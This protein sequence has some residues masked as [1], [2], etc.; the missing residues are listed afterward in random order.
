MLLAAEST[1]PSGGG[2]VRPCTFLPLSASTLK[3]KIKKERGGAASLRVS[4]QLVVS[5]LFGAHTLVMSSLL[6]VTSMLS[7]M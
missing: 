1:G 4:T 2:S 5:F 3:K 7:L 6:Q